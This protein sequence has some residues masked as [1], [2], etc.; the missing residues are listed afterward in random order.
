VCSFTLDDTFIIGCNAANC[1]SVIRD[2]NIGISMQLANMRLLAQQ[3]VPNKHG[4]QIII[5][6]ANNN[7]NSWLE[8]N[9]TSLLT[10][11]TIQFKICI[12][13]FYVKRKD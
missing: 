1:F 4:M 7:Y 5:R 9:H 8:N 3:D 2:R 12:P 6:S 13:V 11:A 10:I